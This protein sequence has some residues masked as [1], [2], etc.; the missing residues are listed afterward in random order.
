MRIQ[1]GFSLIELL[2]VIVI[3]GI[4]AAVAIPRF[5][6]LKTNA[7]QAAVDGIAGSLATASSIN[8]AGCAALGNTVT[9]GKCIKVVKCSDVAASVTPPL[10]LGKAGA[11]IKNTYNLAADT[12]AAG[13]GTETACTLQMSK[14]ETVYT[15]IYTVTGAGQ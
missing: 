6:D 13:N 4:L 10:T 15:A 7:E 5:I 2:M 8:Y 12:A 9:A 3:L 11:A 1:K 14:D